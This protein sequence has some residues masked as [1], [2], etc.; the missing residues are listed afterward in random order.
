MD[1]DKCNGN[2]AECPLY[3]CPSTDDDKDEDSDD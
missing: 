3:S 1:N 2:C